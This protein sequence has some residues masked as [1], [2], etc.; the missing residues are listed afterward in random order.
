MIF[1]LIS[2]NSIHKELNPG[3]LKSLNKAD[4][5]SRKVL[6]ILFDGFDPELAFS[7][8]ENY[9]EMNNFNKLLNSSVTHQKFYAPAK[10]T[11]YS[12][13]AMLIGKNINSAEFIDH[14]YYLISKNE[15]IAFN[16]ENTI[17]G[18]LYNDGY[19]SAISGYGFH[20]YCKMIR[21]VKCKV[22]N[23]PIK[24]YDGIFNILQINRI[25]SHFF[26]I[27][28]HRDINPSI[29]NSMFDFIKS[30]N[31]TN[32]LFVHNRIPHL[33]HQCED[34]LA[35][36]AEKYFNFKFRKKDNYLNLITDRRDAYL[37]NL[38][39]SDS[40]VGEILNL[41]NNDNYIDNETLVI[42]S[43]DHWAKNAYGKFK[44]RSNNEDNKPYPT[45]FIA[46]ILGDNNKFE[47]IEP[48]SGI[49]VQEL[50]QNFLNK[51]INTH[52][53]I[54]KFFQSKIGFQ[55]LMEEDLEFIVE[56]DF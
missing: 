6:W 9:Y 13:P 5:S 23:E 28:S 41:L 42:F 33:C 4:K 40:I 30:D 53:D 11:L 14:R 20:S 27:G 55:V 35:G 52:L 43:A 32:L 36:M 48:D 50:V 7:K 54:Y 51:K 15:K 39:L 22:H 26:K 38:K 24:W 8:E 45:L 1:Q 25:K 21:Y 29:L 34:G 47:I 2:L 10:S 56:K 18:R 3:E 17:F 16:F 19:D 49:H 31:P 46:K 37:I 12:I 44:I